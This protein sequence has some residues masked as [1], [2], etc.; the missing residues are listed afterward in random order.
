MFLLQNEF[1]IKCTVVPLG[2][3]GELSFACGC[4]YLFTIKR[5]RTRTV[6]NAALFMSSTSHYYWTKRGD[7]P[8]GD[9]GTER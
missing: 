5:V 9:S 7:V 8:A 2:A 4:C 1:Q 6:L 3:V